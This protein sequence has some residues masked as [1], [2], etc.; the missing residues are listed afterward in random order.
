ML[1]VRWSFRDYFANLQRKC[2]ISRNGGEEFSV[3]Q[4]MKIAEKF[5]GKVEANIFTIS[6][7]IDLRITV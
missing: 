2:V 5:R 1:V 7:E 6:D 4:A 3:Q